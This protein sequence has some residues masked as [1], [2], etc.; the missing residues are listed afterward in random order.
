MRL[1]PDL[2]RIADIAVFAESEPTERFPSNPPLLVIEIISRDDRYS[3]V[4]GKLLEYQDWG[5]RNIWVIDP[6][7]KRL[8]TYS[9]GALTLTSRVALPGYPLELSA[10]LF[11]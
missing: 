7:R 2:Y 9:S 3:D 1:A 10:E 4:I 6:W 11:S 8:A 5:V